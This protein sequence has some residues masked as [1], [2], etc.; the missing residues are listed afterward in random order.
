MSIAR[1]IWPAAFYWIGVTGT[2]VCFALVLSGNTESVWR[3]EHTGFPLS[4][5]FAGAAA[6]AFLAAEFC[7]SAGS[8]REAEAG[9][10]QLSPELEA[11]E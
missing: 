4:W 2:L 8:P 5:A 1:R 6:L 7:P 11:V 3:F 10:S 9:N